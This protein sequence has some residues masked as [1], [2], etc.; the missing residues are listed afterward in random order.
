MYSFFSKD[1][2]K[3]LDSLFDTCYYTFI[4]IKDVGSK[5]CKKV[6]NPSSGRLLKRNL[7]KLDEETRN[8]CI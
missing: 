4:M 5:L 3:C 2:E 7:M 1:Y 6:V 8:D